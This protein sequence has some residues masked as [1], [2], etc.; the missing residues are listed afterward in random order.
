MRLLVRILAGV[1]LLVVVVLGALAVVLSTIDTRTLIAPVKAQLERATGRAITLGGEA[2]IGL[3][4]TPTLVLNDVAL[5]NAAWGTGKEMVRAKRIEAQVALL[6]LLSRRIDVVR[7]TLVEPAILLETDARGR[8]NWVFVEPAKSAAPSDPVGDAAGAFGLGEFGIDNGTLTWR[9]GRTQDITTVRI[10]R[11]YLRARDPAKPVVAEFRGSIGDIPVSLDGH[12]GSIAALQ[13][14]QWPWPV[15][16]KG[17]VAG[18]KIDAQAKVKAG[19]EA[20]ELTEL[21]YAAGSSRLRGSLAYAARSPRAFVRFDLKGDTVAMNDLALA[22]GA[23]AKAGGAPVK[24]PP[25]PASK[26]DGRIFDAAP[27]PL[28]ALRSIDAE[29]RFEVAKLVLADG[30]TFNAVQLRM[31]LADGRLEVPEWHAGALGGTTQGRLVLDARSERSSTL[32]ASIDGRGL[33]LA[34][35]MALAGVAREVKG[36]KVDVD[37]DV[38][39]RGMSPRDYAS[40]LSGVALVKVGHASWVSSTSGLPAQL[41]QLVVSLN[42]LA[43]KGGTTD[44]QCAVIRLPF[45][46]GVARVDRSIAFET[47]QVGVSAI[48]T[49]D[50][51][52]ETLD[53]ALAP[54]V[55]TRNVADLGKLAGAVRLQ[56]PI[57]EP[58]VAIDPAGSVAA[59]LDIAQLMRGGR[60][61]L[62][63]AL[64]P[65]T[66]TGPGECAVASGAA[67]PAQAAGA[68]PATGGSGR[69]AAPPAAN[70]PAQEL[71][72]ALGR[73]LKR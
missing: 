29:G 40:T 37:V 24:A 64:A 49:I 41:G 22:G 23:A 18:H 43:A 73:L 10:D 5:A 17:D 46:G 44:L 35:V 54:R 52:S 57:S 36:G 31:Q 14:R 65:T 12:F 71:N 50:L 1:A 28:A 33:D 59:A 39:A 70:D 20:I 7:F 34:S 4:L 13:A 19:T 72:R 58:R 32:T 61:A 47:D 8:G 2:R 42:P 51:R 30:R 15:A 53:L 68:P 67:R 9:D 16:V 55:K 3:S 21:E 6:P 60:A 25:A 48:G 63:G 27:L 56:G 69:P 62:Q 26:R 45:S 11:L 38:N 66:P